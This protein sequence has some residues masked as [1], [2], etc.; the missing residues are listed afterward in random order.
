VAIEPGRPLTDVLHVLPRLTGEGIICV[1]QYDSSVSGCLQAQRTIGAHLH[2]PLPRSVTGQV[3]I[4]GQGQQSKLPRR[5]NG[6]NETVG[7]TLVGPP[8]RPLQPKDAV[9]ACG[10][11]SKPTLPVTLR[12]LAAL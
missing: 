4:G 5:A 3:G 10:A 9:P 1:E 2:D 7:T 12:R 6:P 11:W 8:S